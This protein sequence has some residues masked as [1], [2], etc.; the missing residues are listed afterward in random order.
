M[1]LDDKTRTRR[2]RHL[3]E[4]LNPLGGVGSL[5][6]GNFPKQNFLSYPYVLSCTVTVGCVRHLLL[7]CENASEK[8]PVL[9]CAR[10]IGSRVLS[11]S[12][13]DTFA[14]WQHETHDSY[15]WQHFSVSCFGVKSHAAHP[16]RFSMAFEG[17]QHPVL[18]STS[19]QLHVYPLSSVMWCKP[20]LVFAQN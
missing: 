12:A 16:N 17:G 9:G 3:D 8:Y 15:V 1:S 6:L 11:I 7:Q 4:T 20:C 19:N 2:V 18:L 5:S 13:V 14:F 10:P